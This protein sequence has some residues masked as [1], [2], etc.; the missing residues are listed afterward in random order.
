M[1]RIGAFVSGGGKSKILTAMQRDK[2]ARL[3]AG[4]N[5]AVIRLQNEIK[6]NLTKGGAAG[7]TR[8]AKIRGKVRIY[9]RNETDHL[10]VITGKLLGSWKTRKARR[11]GQ[12]IEGHVFTNNV[13]SAI[14]EFG[15][16]AGSPR[17][18]FIMRAH[19]Y[20]RPAMKTVGPQMKADMLEAYMGPMK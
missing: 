5:R 20:V 8:S 18:R 14:H 4:V 10:R 16:P 19:P 2:D 11:V 6:I 17:S 1:I 12:F 3:A 15:G 9:P 13:Y 7:S